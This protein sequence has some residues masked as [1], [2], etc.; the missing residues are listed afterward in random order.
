VTAR[1]H[2]AGSPRSIGR[3]FAL[4]RALDEAMPIYPLYALLFSRSG[5]SDGGIA[6][7]LLL[8]S[9]AVVVFEVPSGAWADV[10]ARHRLLAASGLVRGAGFAAWVLAPSYPGFVLGFVLWA[11]GGSMMSGTLEAHVHDA[12]ER[13][14]AQGEYRRYAGWAQVA[15]ISAMGLATASAPLLLGLGGYLL[16]GLASSAVCVLFA[17]VALLLPDPTA[18]GWRRAA[19]VEAAA[20]AEL[21][22]EAGIDAA[23]SDGIWSAWW[24]ML[25]DGVREATTHPA[26][27]RAVLLAAVVPGVL[28][29]DEVFPLLARTSGFSEEAVPIVMLAVAVA[30]LIGSWAATLP[31]V[32]A[33]LAPVMLGAFG[34]LVAGCL[35]ANV[36]GWA[37]IAVGY[38]LGQA[39]VV[40]VDARVQAVVQGQARATVTSVAG[41]GAEILA[42]GFYA[43]W[44]VSAGHL[45]R[46]GA[47]ALLTFPLLLALP[48]ALR[49]SRQ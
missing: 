9:V 8:W 27:R 41:F 35:A 21:T 3:W 30:Q 17:V 10:V 38:G 4:V 15:A 49:S 33:R 7:L 2:V 25:R 46:P 29:L 47:T 5:V 40:L 24:R 44:G 20:G 1:G 26:V 19:E 28:A 13:H 16:V 43:V 12:L 42:G 36:P 34:L 32:D 14:G 39:A 11:L 48:L 45:G 6:G 18:T 31:G 22:A 23:G 37:A